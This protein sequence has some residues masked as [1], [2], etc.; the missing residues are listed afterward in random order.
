MAMV[1]FLPCLS[2]E[3][4][5]VAMASTLLALGLPLL[6]RREGHYPLRRARFGSDPSFPCL[7]KGAEE[8]AMVFALLV[9]TGRGLP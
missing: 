4:W 9:V 7:Q 1:V 5:G 2:K 6:V 8:V 3:L